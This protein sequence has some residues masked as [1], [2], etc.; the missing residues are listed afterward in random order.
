MSPPGSPAGEVASARREGGP[1]GPA[2]APADLAGARPG[3][4]LVRVAG[5][6]QEAEGIAGFTLVAADGGL[7]PAFAAGAHVDVH[8]P[9]A[10]PGAAWVVRPYSLCTAPPPPGAAGVPHYELG[11]LLEP[12]SRG[13]SAGL[14]QRVSVGDLLHIGLPRNL[15]GLA[16]EARRSLLLAGGIGITPLLSMAQALWAQGRDFQL[17]HAVRS[18]RRAPYVERLAAVPWADR[19][20][21]HVDDGPADQRLDLPT[22]LAAPLPGDHLYLC[23]PQ[24]FMDAV[25]AAATAAGWPG[26][27]V[28]C[29][30]FG[31]APAVASGP[32]GQ[33]AFELQLGHGG[34]VI[35]VAADQTAV[36]ALAAAGITVLTSCEQGVCGTCLTRVLDGTPEHRGQYLTPEE[37]AAGDQFLPCCSRALTARLVLDLGG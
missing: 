27:Q 25:R 22:L 36:Q 4:V 11:V 20:H 15:F 3:T 12:A 17:H 26:A 14:H 28:H 10:G 16:A 23:G 34:R 19:V 24:G 9:P 13:G 18:A 5:K 33:G 7:L 35:P 21:R 1:A 6:T 31:A 2:R 32:A 30:S 8:L 29:E 37:Q